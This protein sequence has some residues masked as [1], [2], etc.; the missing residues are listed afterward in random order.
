MKNHEPFTRGYAPGRGYHDIGG[1]DYGPVEA[2]V[3]DCWSFFFMNSQNYIF[4]GAVTFY[5]EIGTN[6][7]PVI[8]P[9]AAI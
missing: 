6:A 9:S 4:N 5:Q 3:T 7:I 1:K 8:Y 2:T